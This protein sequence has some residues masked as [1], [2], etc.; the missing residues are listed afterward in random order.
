MRR[1]AMSR[2]RWGSG[3]CLDPLLLAGCSGAHEPPRLTEKQTSELERALADKVPGEKTSCVNRESQ[4][5]LTAISNSVLLYQVSRRQ[6]Y[7]NDLIGRC[8]G[9]SRG[10]KP[11]RRTEGTQRFR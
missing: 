5:N 6:V 2:V 7:R 10:D 8:T 11:L 1:G 3:L 4:S 9:L